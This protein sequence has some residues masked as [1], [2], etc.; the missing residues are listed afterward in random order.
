MKGVEDA[1]FKHLKVNLKYN[2]IDLATGVLNQTVE[3]I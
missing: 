1:G 2:L 3:Q